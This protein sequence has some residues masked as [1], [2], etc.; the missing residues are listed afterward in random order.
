ME[1]ATIVTGAS[2]GIGA[3]IARHVV[4]RGPVTTLQ[5]SPGPAGTTHRAVDLSD[6]ELAVEAVTEAV[7]DVWSP[8]GDGG[9]GRVVLVHAAATIAPIGFAGEVDADAVLAA[10][11]L[12][13]G[14]AFA[15][16]QAFLAAVADRSGRRQLC[17]FTSGAATTV[18]E[19]WSSYGPAKAAVDHWVAT[20]A[21]EQSRRGGVEVV[22]VSPGV[23]ATAMQE[24]IRDTDERDFPPVGRFRDLHADGDLRD[25][26]VVADEV[27]SLLDGDVPTGE[28]VD[29]R[30]R[31]PG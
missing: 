8:P 23:V 17:Q 12:N 30:T 20:V 2:S 31:R 10:V 21:A 27:W 14:A 18:Y 22:G 13:V 29:L 28:A 7:H 25:P 9:P 5:R 6:L 11:R 24:V 26:D 19:G 3:A 15:V 16:G 1:Q 4:D